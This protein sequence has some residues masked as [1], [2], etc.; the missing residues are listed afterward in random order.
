M[1]N[2]TVHLPKEDPRIEALR[3]CDPI[4]VT[5]TVEPGET[6]AEGEAFAAHTRKHGET[7]EPWSRKAPER[8]QDGLRPQA[9]LEVPEPARLRT[10]AERAPRRNPRSA[11]RLR[12][13]PITPA[14]QGHGRANE[15][16]PPLG[17]VV[18]TDLATC[19]SSRFSAD[20]WY[21]SR[22]R[23]IQI[24]GLVLYL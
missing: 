13:L 3:P 1:K 21:G 5:V 2:S 12:V 15:R 19:S 11:W 4:T 23:D 8:V 22:T 20:E 10:V 17:F 9:R 7:F 24:N 6:P 18:E 16:S 14:N